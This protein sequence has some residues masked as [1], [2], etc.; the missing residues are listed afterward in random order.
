MKSD[1]VVMETDA[2]K[3]ISFITLNRPKR[4]N[5]LSSQLIAELTEALDLCTADGSTQVVILQGAPQFFCVGADITE[6]SDLAGAGGLYGYLDKVRILFQKIES[7]SNPVIAAIQGYALGGGC[8]MALA[9]DLRVAS[10]SAQFG[11][12]EIKIGAIPGGGGISR[13]PRVVGLACAKEMVF[14]GERISAQEAYRIGLVNRVFPD[15]RFKEDLLSYAHNLAQ[16]APLAVRFS[17]QAMNLAFSLDQT[18]SRILEIFSGSLVH[19]SEDRM[20]GMKAFLEKR[21]PIFRGM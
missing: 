17:K 2:D 10:E 18:S 4:M 21:N 1:T 12:P 16:K 8:E 6:V 3:K 7:L 9:C 14:F 5:A 19:G 20:E 11:L 13:L 15:D